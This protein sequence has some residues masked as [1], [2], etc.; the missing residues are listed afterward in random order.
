MAHESFEDTQ[1][2]TL[3][4]E[5]FVNIKVDR[6]ER[7]DLDAIYMSA[8]VSLTGQG[9]WPMSVFITPDL[10]PFYGGTYFPP[11][12]RYNMPPFREVLTAISRLWQEDRSRLLESSDQITEVLRHSQTTGQSSASLNEK[13]LNQAATSLA[14]GYDWENG[15]W[16]KAPKFPQPM[17]IEF[18]LRKATA[19]R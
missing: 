13:D 8:I 17:T 10:K 5:F 19:R 15:G 14:Q 6:E 11:I 1:T 3:M 12:R 4:N 7:P 9:G 18:L 2:A 16:G